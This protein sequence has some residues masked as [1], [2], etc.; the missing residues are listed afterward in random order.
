MDE[1]TLFLRVIAHYAKAF[2][3]M[4][5]AGVF[6]YNSGVFKSLGEDSLTSCQFSRGT[7]YAYECEIP[8]WATFGTFAMWIVSLVFIVLAVRVAKLANEGLR[9]IEEVK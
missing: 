8:V 1:A 6:F 9:V 5:I 4:I 7:L 3:F 2:W